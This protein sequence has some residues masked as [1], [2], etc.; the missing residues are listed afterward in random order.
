M[1]AKRVAPALSLGSLVCAAQLADLLWPSF[2]LAGLER[3]E[4]RPGV[5]AVTPLDFVSYPYS[6]SL[7]A[8]AG[9]GLALALAHRVGRRAGTLAAATLAA[10]V[11]S[12]WA[13][14]WIVHRPDL[15]LTVGGAGRYG[16][17]LWGSLPATLAVELGLFATGLAV[18]AR[19]TSAR[20]RAGRWG[21]LGFAAVLAIIELANLLGP[22]PPSVAA[23]T[24]SAHAVWLLVAWAWWVDRHRAVRGVAT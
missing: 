19:T 2:V 1:A 14:D 11:V 9:W 5:T 4:I 6:H 13:L 7:A 12:H 10:L 21:L 22:P 16:L 3:F 20:D 8:L 15:P 24:W 23:V 17:G 18:Y